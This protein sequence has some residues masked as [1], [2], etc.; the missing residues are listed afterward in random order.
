MESNFFTGMH[1]SLS[2]L[3]QMMQ[4]GNGA[5]VNICSIGGKLPVPHLL[6]YTASKFAAVGFS[7]GLHAEMRAKGV[8]VLTVCPGLIRTGSHVSAM[9]SGNA[10]RE[11][12]WFSF[13]ANMPGISTSA[14]AAARRIVRAVIARDTEITITPYAAIASRMAGVC[15]EAVALAMSTANRLLPRAAALTAE[16]RKGADLVSAGEADPG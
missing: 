4:R 13:A 11:Y 16:P 6:P 10:E 8:H 3:P 1:C 12:R 14:A 2:V 5:I 9:F 15:P 7:Q